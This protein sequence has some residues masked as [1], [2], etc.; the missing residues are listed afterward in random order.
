MDDTKSAKSISDIALKP[1]AD[2]CRGKTSQTDLVEGWYSD[3]PTEDNNL[4]IHV[5][6]GELKAGNKTVLIGVGNKVLQVTGVLGKREFV[7]EKT[8]NDL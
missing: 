6:N 8:V 4:S 1:N 3:S 2:N 7:F 5:S